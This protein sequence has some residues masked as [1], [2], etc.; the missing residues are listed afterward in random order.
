M[1]IAYVSTFDARLVHSWSGTGYTIA[2]ELEKQGLEISYVGPLTEK[3]SLLYKA[4]QLFYR[5]IL[6]KRHIR[7]AE[8]AIVLHNALQISKQIEKIKPDIILAIWAYPIALLDCKQPIVFIADATFPLMHNYYKEYSNLSTSTI[9]NIK[10]L[11]QSALNRSAAVIYSSQWAAQS[12]INEYNTSPDKVYVVPFGANIDV[13][14]SESEI[15]QFIEKRVKN[16]VCKLLFLGVDWE[17]K[18]GNIALNTAINLHNKGIK[19][20]LNIVGCV[21][22]TTKL[23]HFVN[24]IGFLNKSDPTDVIKLRKLFIESHFLI[25]PS[26]A[27]CTPIVFSEANSFGLPCISTT[28][29]GIPSVIINGKNGQLFDKLDS[30][31]EFSQ[32]IAQLITNPEEY[33]KLAHSSFLEYKQRLNWDFAGY[34]IKKILENLL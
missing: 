1:K 29:G 13:P 26:I 24:L 12:A 25:L 3:N 8:P 33:Y 21:P 2:K 6:R 27:D 30:P 28:V 18:G 14:P 5:E 11:E 16:D 23:P 20:E 9:R 31:E 22:T 7:Q 32:Y 19:T 34:Q 4:K 10:Q 17:R 15:E